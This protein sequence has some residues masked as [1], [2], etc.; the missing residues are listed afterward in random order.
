[1]DERFD[2]KHPHYEMLK[3][4]TKEELDKFFEDYP[5]EAK[6]VD[7]V[8][9]DDDK[10]EYELNGEK[11]RVRRE[12]VGE[13]YEIS[14]ASWCMELEEWR[15]GFKRKRENMGYD[16]NF[17]VLCSLEGGRDKEML[18]YAYG[19][20]IELEEDRPYAKKGTKLFEL[21]EIYVFEEHQNKGHGKRIVNF[22]IEHEKKYNKAEFMTVV[23]DS[24]RYK[25]ILHFFIDECGL[26]FWNALLVRQISGI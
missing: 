16:R 1:M 21:E 22:A 13:H 6:V 24:K 10:V 18:G 4:M 12:Y 20:T 8:Y 11:Y 25:D 26:E 19:R 23:A 17:Y 14:H 5:C 3:N 15:N 7:G 9:V 2:E